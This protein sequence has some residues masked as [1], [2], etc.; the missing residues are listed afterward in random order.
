MGGYEMDELIT[1]ARSSRKAIATFK[2]IADAMLVSGYYSPTDI[3]GRKLTSVLKEINPEIF[4]TMNDPRKV[5]LSGLE[6]VINRLP[7]GIEKCEKIVMT[8]RED[9]QSTLFEKRMPLKRRR[10]AYAVSESELCFIITRGESELYDILTHIVFFLNEANKICEHIDANESGIDGDWA[11]IERVAKLDT[12]PEGLELDKAIWNLSKF[13]GRSYSATKA[14]YDY[15]EKTRI[16]NDANN[17]LFSI[18]YNMGSLAKVINGKAENQFRMIYTPALYDM[19]IDQKYAK[20]WATALKEEVVS[21]GLT[22]RPIH[23]VSANLHSF[24][25]LLYGYEFLKTKDIDVAGDIVAMVKG[26]QPFIPELDQYAT[27]YGCTFFTDNS[28]SNIDV[29]IIDSQCL[30]NSQLD[31]ISLSQLEDTEIAPII[32]VIDYAF[33][34]Q[35]FKILDELLREHEVYP[36]FSLNVSSISI[37]GKAGILDG[38]K[39]DI[40]LATA[41]VL[42]GTPDNY[43]VENDVTETDFS[44]KPDHIDVFTGSMLTVLGTSLQNGAILER[45]HNSRWGFVGLEMEGGHYQRAIGAGIIRK[46][47][48]KEINVRYIYYASDNPLVPGET[49]ASGAMGE[50]GLIPT[51]LVTKVI[52]RKIFANSQ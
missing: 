43:I 4:G 49:L 14:T 38:K 7:K 18:I 45:L 3:N 1:R 48:S 24:R 10:L 21:K 42:E 31:N 11:E 17:S 39:G 23:I 40:M 52:L 12:M 28:G 27:G 30:T 51:Y 44:E 22:D 6:Y 19:I 5:E 15:L 34:T 33:G 36:E 8:T 25:N 2:T 26:V 29:H 47:L 41:H 35:A 37:M 16:E 32:I 20:D 13:L 50:T 46:R 9:F